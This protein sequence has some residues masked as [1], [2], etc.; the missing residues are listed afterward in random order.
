MTWWCMEPLDSQDNL[1]SSMSTGEVTGNDKVA[2]PLNTT[3]IDTPTGPLLSTGC[4]GRLQVEARGSCTL[5]LTEP[6]K[7]SP[8]FPVAALKAAV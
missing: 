6:A 8:S 7:L 4:R 2:S 3:W 1:L 5:F